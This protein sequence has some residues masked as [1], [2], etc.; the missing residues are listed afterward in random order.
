[1]SQTLQISQ[2]IQDIFRDL[3]YVVQDP[4]SSCYLSVQAASACSCPK[5]LQF[6][7]QFQYLESHPFQHKLTW[8]V[9]VKI[10]F[11]IFSSYPVLFP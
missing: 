11:L 6:F 7:I 2:D 8:Y 5:H 4:Q 1:M 10:L 3:V 9:T